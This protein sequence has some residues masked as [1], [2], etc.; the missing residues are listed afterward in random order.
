MFLDLDAEDSLGGDANI[1]VTPSLQTAHDATSSK[2]SAEMNATLSLQA[3]NVS[4]TQE[5]QAAD[6]SYTMRTFRPST[7]TTRNRTFVTPV[8][9]SPEERANLTDS[10]KNIL[11]T[12]Q[13]VVNASNPSGSDIVDFMAQMQPEELAPIVNQ[14]L[15]GQV[16]VTGNMTT[17]QIIEQ[18]KQHM[19]VTNEAL[20]NKFSEMIKELSGI[21]INSPDSLIGVLSTLN[22]VLT[23]SN[24]W[25][26][27]GGL[28]SI[29]GQLFGTIHAAKFRAVASKFAVSVSGN[30]VFIVGDIRP[31]RLQNDRPV[32]M[33]TDGDSVGIEGEYSGNM[34]AS[35][36][37]G[38]YKKRMLCSGKYTYRL[39]NNAELISTSIPPTTAYR[40]QLWN[41]SALSYDG[42]AQNLKNTSITAWIPIRD[43]TLVMKDPVDVLD[44]M[45]MGAPFQGESL[46]FK[47]DFEGF[48][49]TVTYGYFAQCVKLSGPQ[50]H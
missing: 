42:K 47:T 22:S 20:S 49:Y 18:L 29:S 8:T 25:S 5:S 30:E 48:S 4:A 33:T 43:A 23:G 38:P 10:L 3:A 34:D 31:A 35:C 2:Q 7:A 32:V 50:N 46:S 15:G 17:D 16:Q 6:M 13:S 24:S 45:A 36:K 37:P 9:L 40:I 26:V 44:K 1:K 12:L 11:N 19:N 41:A 21:T 28:P 39:E 14:M 27:N